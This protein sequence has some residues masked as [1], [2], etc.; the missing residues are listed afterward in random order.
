VHKA[1]GTAA[2][3]PGK[4]LAGAYEHLED[5]I[6]PYCW[7][8][9]DGKQYQVDEDPLTPAK[10]HAKAEPCAS[11]A[12]DPACWVDGDGGDGV[13]YAGGGCVLGGVL[14]G[15]S[16]ASR[17]SACG[18]TEFTCIAAAADGAA[19]AA[20][21]SEPPMKMYCPGQQTHICVTQGAATCCCCESVETVVR[22]YCFDLDKCQAAG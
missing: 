19:E 16:I 20:R 9:A 6:T 1:V 5:Y 17:A 15:G 14:N 21:K 2:R 13:G 11:D 4:L 8:A 7:F 18:A 10:P 3:L 22:R 12:A